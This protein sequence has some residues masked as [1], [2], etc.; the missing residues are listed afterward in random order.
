MPNRARS[1]ED[2]QE[3]QF[4]EL[5][6]IRAAE[7]NSSNQQ[8]VWKSTRETE[9]RG[10][11]HQKIRWVQRE[12]VHLGPFQRHL[13]KCQ[14]VAAI[15]HFM[16]LSRASSW[17][18][19]T[20]ILMGTSSNTAQTTPAM[21]PVLHTSV[22]VSPFQAPHPQLHNMDP[23]KR[24]QKGCPVLLRGHL[25]TGEVDP[26]SCSDTRRWCDLQNAQVQL[27]RTGYVLMKNCNYRKQHTS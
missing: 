6:T 14:T 18:P 15:K 21:S 8:T 26:N 22:H 17:W 13:A 25:S 12:K 5:L 23:H 2:R 9:N 1:L 10:W 20:Q 7:K 19:Q 4:Q 16:S 24:L 11:E 27:I 3:R